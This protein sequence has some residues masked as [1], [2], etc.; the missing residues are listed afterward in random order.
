MSVQSSHSPVSVQST[1]FVLCQDKI[2]QAPQF[3]LR[4]LGWMWLLTD[5][6]AP[7]T[8]GPSLMSVF[9]I[10][11]HHLLSISGMYKKH[12]REKKR[13]Y[14][15]RIREV[16]HGCFTPLVLSSTGGLGRE[17]TIAFKRIA[18]RLSTKWDRPYP[19]V[20]SWIRCS[21]SFSLLRSSIRC[22]SV[23]TA[24]DAAHL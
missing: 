24:Q 15:A 21:L 12:E 13:E 16:E 8:R 18:S 2:S 1:H 20:L 4:V 22:A 11:W 10:L 19:S 6:G 14:G 5:S 9:S 23:A 3:V 7:A 17:A